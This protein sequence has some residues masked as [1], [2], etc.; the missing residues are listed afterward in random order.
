M[1]LKSA[2][3]IVH[4][5]SAVNGIHFFHEALQVVLNETNAIYPNDSGIGRRSN[6]RRD[7]LLSPVYAE[8]R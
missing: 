2:G 8:G 3:L 1:F 6:G 4:V 5:R 7:C